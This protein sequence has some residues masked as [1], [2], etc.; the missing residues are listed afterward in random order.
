MRTNNFKG[1]YYLLAILSFCSCEKN[2]GLYNNLKDI[3]TEIGLYDFYLYDVTKNENIRITSS[4]DKIES[5]YSIS[6]DSKKILYTN[7]SGICIMNINGS[8]N[9]VIISKGSSP[10]FSR[11]GEKVIF[12]DENKLFSINI[13]GSNKSQIV[14]ADFALWY[15]VLSKDGKKIACSSDRGLCIVSIDGQIDIISASN[16]ADWYDWSSDSK[17]LFYSRFIS[18]NFAQIYKYNVIE[19][20]EYQLTNIKK[21]N[22]S[23]VCNLSTSDI[24]FSSSH[25]DYGG[26]LVLMNTKEL[27]INTILHKDNISS[28]FWSPSGNAVTFITENSNLA[29]VDKDGGNY[30]V[31]NEIPGACMSPVWS[32][33]GKFI[34]YYRALLYN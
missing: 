28:P 18:D 17:E 30:R 13:D 32:P 7:N 33:N 5:S 20:K 23:P 22:Y 2:D 3:D 25:A 9:N 4:P 21:Y 19:N 8:G 26:D 11:D 27:N 15:P 1:L 6:P 31:I 16:S 34:L 29:I 24:I 12:I 14:N 10:C